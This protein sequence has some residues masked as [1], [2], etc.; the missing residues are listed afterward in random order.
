M[1]PATDGS[2]VV[3]RQPNRLRHSI[4][5]RRLAEG[6]HVKQTKPACIITCLLASKQHSGLMEAQSVVI[7]HP[8]CSVTLTGSDGVS[9][10][11]DD[12]AGDA[13]VGHP[14]DALL[15]KHTTVLLVGVTRRFAARINGPLIPLMTEQEWDLK[16]TPV[17]LFMHLVFSF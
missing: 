17:G 7:G 8:A 6:A 1:E 16:A 14:R 3:N 11:V 15:P 4:T 2:D 9:D 12:D 13:D 10:D 5:S